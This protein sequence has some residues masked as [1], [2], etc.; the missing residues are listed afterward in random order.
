MARHLTAVVI[1]MTRVVRHSVLHFP[2]FSSM[3]A[4]E[5]AGPG[6]Y[7]GTHRATEKGIT[8]EN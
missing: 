5:P 7:Y 2:W 4:F 6:F 1:S 8:S 3:F